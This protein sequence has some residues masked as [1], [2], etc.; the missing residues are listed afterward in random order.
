M[1]A[2]I[3]VEKERDSVDANG[4]LLGVT[5]GGKEIRVVRKMSGWLAIFADGGQL[6][7]SLSGC[8]TTFDRLQHAV[9]VYLAHKPKTKKKFKKVSID[10]GKQSDMNPE[11]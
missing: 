5:D 4:S 9:E 6:P 8:F 7:K 3:I 11:S 10:R 1:T 2:H